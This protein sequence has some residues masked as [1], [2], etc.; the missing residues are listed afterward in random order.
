MGSVEL[1][2]N[3]FFSLILPAARD[4]GRLAGSTVALP[5]SRDLFPGRGAVVKSR[6]KRTS[7]LPPNVL[8]Q[9][10]RA[11]A[12]GKLQPGTVHMIDVRHESRCALLSGKGACNC[13]P[14]VMLPERVAHPEEN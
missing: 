7:S 2:L 13:N 6:R 4:F 1:N 14:E 10:A 11:Q 12:E 3:K 9:I 8:Q 5:F